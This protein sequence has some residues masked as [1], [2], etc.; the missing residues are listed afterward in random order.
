MLMTEIVL[1]IDAGTTGVRSML[2]DKSGTVLGSAYS[3]YESMFPSPSWVEQNAES[4]WST[5]CDTIKSAMAKAG[6][7]A[8]K[9]VCPKMKS[10]R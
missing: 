6:L 2:F 7:G 9:I 8:E 3:E 10:T 5:S 4:W 1:A